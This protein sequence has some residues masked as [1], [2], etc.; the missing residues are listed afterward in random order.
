MTKNKVIEAAVLPDMLD[1]AIIPVQ[2]LN[3][4]AKTVVKVII[5]PVV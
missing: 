5:F 2:P 3:M 1:P 4:T